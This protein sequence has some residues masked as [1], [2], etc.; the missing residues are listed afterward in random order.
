M[1]F[2]QKPSLTARIDPGLL[3]LMDGNFGLRCSWESRDS[4]SELLWLHV[5]SRVIAGLVTLGPGL[6][7]STLITGGLPVVD[8]SFLRSILI[9]SIFM[10][11]LPTL[12]WY[13]RWRGVFGNGNHIRMQMAL[14]NLYRVLPYMNSYYIGNKGLPRKFVYI[15]YKTHCSR[16]MKTFWVSL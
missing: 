16:S 15:Y 8:G 13:W 4:V 1:W 6:E 7:L 12:A 2:P 11:R 5:P 10:W 14:F 9:P 3:W